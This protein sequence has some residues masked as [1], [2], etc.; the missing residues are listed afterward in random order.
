MKKNSNKKSAKKIN[1]KRPAYVN[2]FGF[3]IKETDASQ[4]FANG[5]LHR[6][7]MLLDRSDGQWYGTMTEFSRAITT[8]LHRRVPASWPKNPSIMRRYVNT[9][10]TNLRKEGIRVQFGRGTDHNRT[11]FVGFEV[12]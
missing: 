12:R 1:S 7:M 9:I 6:I 3:G 11:R 5:L 4:D 2:G 10:A 8:G